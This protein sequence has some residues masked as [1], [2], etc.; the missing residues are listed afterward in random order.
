VQADQVGGTFVIIL[1]RDSILNL[2][3]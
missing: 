3:I 2:W 1:P